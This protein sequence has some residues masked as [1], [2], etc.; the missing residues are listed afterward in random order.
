ML[1]LTAA[2]SSK[3]FD[4]LQSLNHSV[5]TS[6][7]SEY[8]QELQRSQMEQEQP[9]SPTLPPLPTMSPQQTFLLAKKNS[10]FIASESNDTNDDVP[11]Q[12]VEEEEEEE[13][14]LTTLVDITSNSQ[15]QEF[16]ASDIL[17]RE[18]VKGESPRIDFSMEGSE[19]DLSMN[20]DQPLDMNEEEEEEDD[21]EE[22]DEVVLR[23]EEDEWDD[24]EDL[25]YVVLKITEQEFFEMEE[26]RKDRIPASAT[27][28]VVQAGMCTVVIATIYFLYSYVTVAYVF[29]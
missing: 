12:C 6:R 19:H 2:S 21:D 17:E 23:N 7:W 25:G 18:Q 20:K 28:C 15:D 22:E 9:N 10:F 1:P 3:Q 4:I 5:A 16:A 29:V 13:G 27:G 14:E 8:Q 11:H 24:D 26:V